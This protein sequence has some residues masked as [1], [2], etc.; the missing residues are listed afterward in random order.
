MRSA[1]LGVTLLSLIAG[2]A[3]AQRGFNR[4]A[5][6]VRYQ[7]RVFAR[8]AHRATVHALFVD[9]CEGSLSLRA[10]APEEGGVRVSTWAQRV[11]AVAAINGDYFDLR[12]RAPLGPARGAGRWWPEGPRGHRDALFVA[13]SAGRVDILDADDLEAARWRDAPARVAPEWTEVLA[14][15]ERVL[16]RG[17][18]RESPALTE[19][20]RRHPRTAL[21]LSEDR[22]TLMLVVIE[23][24]SERDSGA[25]ARELGE[26]LLALG[27]WE[28][29]KLDGGGS[30]AM[31][32]AGRGVVNHPSDG[33]ERAVATHLGVLSRA[34]PGSR[35]C[36]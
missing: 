21:G 27:A 31:F 28:G 6:G 2:A 29:M 8:G 11:G 14:V 9:L 32:V 35:R 17:R 24:R 30:S 1:A 12:R 4:P 26:T 34:T 16:V 25:T 15:R 22:R 13:D 3:H 19:R 7:R 33:R 10:T 23:G 20:D 36:R 5:P 18:V